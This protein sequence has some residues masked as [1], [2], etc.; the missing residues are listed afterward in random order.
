[1]V[2]LMREKEYQPSIRLAGSEESSPLRYIKDIEKRKDARGLYPRKGAGHQYNTYL[3]TCIRPGMFVSVCG[4][5][6]STTVSL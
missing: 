5:W 3:P 2:M 6:C 1:M 4:G